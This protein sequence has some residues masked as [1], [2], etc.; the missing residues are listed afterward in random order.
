MQFTPWNVSCPLSW[1]V[2]WSLVR[3][4]L[5][6]ASSPQNGQAANTDAAPVGAAPVC[7]ISNVISLA[8]VGWGGAIHLRQFVN[9]A[10][11]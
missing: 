4:V 10:H 5:C 1:M 8:P 6:A 11:E 9:A 3:M 2:S 7:D